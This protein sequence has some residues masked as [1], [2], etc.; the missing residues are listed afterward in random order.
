MKWTSMNW[1]TESQNAWRRAKEDQ[2]MCPVCKR[3]FP[4]RKAKTLHMRTHRPPPRQLPK[5][6]RES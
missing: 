6:E 1:T 2:V 4:S 3:K 5:K